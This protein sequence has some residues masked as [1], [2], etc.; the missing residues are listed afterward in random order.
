MDFRNVNHTDRVVIGACVLSLISFGI[1]AKL[2]SIIPLYLN[3]LIVLSALIYWSVRRDATGMLKRSVIIG[4]IAGICYTFMDKL[5]VETRIITYLRSDVNIF[6]TP[7]SVVLIWMCCITIAI[8]F[9][10]RL[11][12]VF[13]R[14]YMPS[15]LTGAGAFISGTILNELGGHARLWV[16][17]IGVPSSFAIGSTPV[18]VPVALFATFFLSPYIIGGQRITRRIG[19]QQNSIAAGLRCAIILAMMIFLSF[20]IF[21]R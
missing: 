8:Y 9:Y 17:N 1:D 15:I 14:F 3:G 21:T 2:D 18:F 5:F 13:S 6:K 19:L 4:S 7:A 20:R 12:S 11:R 16:W 10:Q